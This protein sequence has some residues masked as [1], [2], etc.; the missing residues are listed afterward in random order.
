M[1]TA[2]NFSQ[3]FRFTSLVQKYAVNTQLWRRKLQEKEEGRIL[4][5]PQKRSVDRIERME[6]PVAEATVRIVCTDPDAEAEKI[7]QLLEAMKQARIEAGESV[8]NLDPAAFQQTPDGCG[9]YA[10]T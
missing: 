3:R 2:L 10:F 9:G 6:K 7:T 1:P 8:S 4:G 5:A